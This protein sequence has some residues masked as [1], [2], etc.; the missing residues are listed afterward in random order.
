LAVRFL[1]K[2]RAACPLIRPGL[3]CHSPCTCSPRTLQSAK[4]VCRDNHC[5]FFIHLAETSEEVYQIQSLYGNRP[6]RYLESLGVLDEQTVAVHAVHLEPFEIEILARAGTAVSHC[7][8][9]NMKLAAGVA[10]VSEMLG[11][12]VRIGLGTDGAASNNDLDLFREMGTAAR[13]GKISRGEPTAMDSRT[14]FSLATRGGAELLAMSDAIGSL[15]TGKKA[16]LVLL[17]LNQA[18]WNPLYDPCSQLVYSA[19]GADVRTVFVDGRMVVRDRRI[20]TFDLEE[21]LE[22]V[23]AISR[24]IIPSSRNPRSS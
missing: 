14:V 12:G 6:V 1:E 13:L 2:W 24:R 11:Q 21:A 4:T 3:F 20:L 5:L 16:D 10:P 18:H 23:A 19:S 22:R 7:P 9:S 17:D 8:E 15:E